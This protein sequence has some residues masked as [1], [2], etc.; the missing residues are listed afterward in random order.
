[1]FFED[2]KPQTFEALAKKSRQELEQL[3]RRMD[4]DAD[5]PTP[6]LVDRIARRLG[7]RQPV[8]QRR[9]GHR[10]RRWIHN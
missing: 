5:A 9:F 10:K 7:L 3:A 1:M 6:E 8:P 2:D 4:I